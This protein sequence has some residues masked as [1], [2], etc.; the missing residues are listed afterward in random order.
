MENS[1]RVL[2]IEGLIRDRIDQAF[3]AAQEA[4]HIVPQ[5]IGALDCP[6]NYG[7]QARTISPT[8]K[9]SYTLDALGHV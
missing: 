9:N 3:V 2:P 1:A 5:S 4:D 8:G 7:V 6:P